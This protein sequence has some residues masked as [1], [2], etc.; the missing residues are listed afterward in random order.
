M[1][2][3]ELPHNESSKRQFFGQYFG[4]GSCRIIDFDMS[5]SF[6]PDIQEQG[7]VLRHAAKFP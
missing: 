6:S 3:I 5:T 2:M 4:E 1:R 7:V